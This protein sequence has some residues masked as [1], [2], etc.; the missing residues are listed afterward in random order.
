MRVGLS[1]RIFFFQDVCLYSSLLLNVVSVCVHLLGVGFKPLLQ[2]VIY[3][4]LQ[5][6]GNKQVSIA[7]TAHATLK[8]TAAHCGYK[9]VW[10]LSH[11]TIT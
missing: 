1:S 5:C 7:T 3:P 8:R 11:M 2:C 6:L 10:Y 4:L 9:W